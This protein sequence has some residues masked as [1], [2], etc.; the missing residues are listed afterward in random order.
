[1]DKEKYKIKAKLGQGATA[2]VYKAVRYK[3]IMGSNFNDVNTQN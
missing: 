1:L 3:K 2:K